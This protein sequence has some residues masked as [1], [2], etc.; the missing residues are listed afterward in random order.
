MT[1]LTIEEKALVS[2]AY[3]GGKNPED[4]ADEYGLDELAVM[5]Y[6]ADEFQ[7]F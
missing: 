3:K 1:D 6:C 7:D 5:E 2:E 4:I